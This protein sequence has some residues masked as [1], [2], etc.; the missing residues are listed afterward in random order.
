M[1]IKNNDIVS[2]APKILEMHFNGMVDL[3]KVSEKF[4]ADEIVNSLMM[5]SFCYKEMPVNLIGKERLFPFLKTEIDRE[6]DFY[7]AKLAIDKFI[8]FASIEI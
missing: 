7:V 3:S 6:Q 8:F 2:F 4:N 5:V 1:N